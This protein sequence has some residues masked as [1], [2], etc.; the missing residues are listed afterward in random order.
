MKQEELSDWL[1]GLRAEAARYGHLAIT[2]RASRDAVRVRA[3]MR[4][5][6]CDFSFA[7]EAEAPSDAAGRLV[8]ALD[9]YSSAC[10]GKCPRAKE[11]SSPT[12][13]P[14]IIHAISNGR[15]VVNT[16][17]R[18]VTLYLPR[19]PPRMR[20][21]VWESIKATAEKIGVELERLGYTFA[22]EEP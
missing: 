1:R 9:T 8:M 10:G 11:S 20:D 12:L 3:S 18:A 14:L 2:A 4:C 7:V 6:E 21:D 22:T 5:G 16:R 15:L 19:R 17:T 13:D